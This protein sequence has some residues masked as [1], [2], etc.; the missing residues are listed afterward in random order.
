MRTTTQ[1][2]GFRLNV[3]LPPIFARI[4][5]LAIAVA[6]LL[7]S[8]SL[9]AGPVQNVVWENTVGVT[10]TG[11]SLT[12]GSST[13]A[14]NAG[15]ISTVDFASGNGYVQFTATETNTD[16]M[17]GMS[18][19][20]SSQ[21]YTDID[22]AVDLASNGQF[23]VFEDGVNRGSFGSYSTGDVFLV[24]VSGGVVSYS[25][26]GTLFYTSSATPSF[27]VFADASLETP[28]ATISTVKIS[29][30]LQSLPVLAPVFSVAAGTYPTAQT[31]TI[32][33]GTPGAQI[34]YTTDGSTPTQSSQSIASGGTV[35][36]AST[37]TLQLQAFETGL[38][39]STIATANYV[40]NNG[41]SVAWTNGVGVI[42]SGS[43]LTRGSGSAGWTAGAI[44]NT[45]IASG[46]GY[47]Q[48][49]A[50]E[51]NTY[52]MCGL[53]HDNSSEDYTD[54]DFA[55]YLAGNGQFYVYENGT[56]RGGFGSYSTGD[57]FTVAL[58]GG[59]IMYS[60][61]GT[62]FY[63]SSATPTL[64][65]FADVSLYS[66]G[67]TADNFV[68]SGTLQALLVDAPVFS[69]AAGTY[70]TTQSVTITDGT[71][72][73]QIYYTTN[74]STPT[75]SSQSIASGGTVLVASTL[76]LMAQAFE[77]GYTA[78][79]V[80]TAA[81][82]IGSA[83]NV[84]W[85]NGVDVTTSGNNLTR[86]SDTAGWTAGAIS[87]TEI[88]SGNGYVQ[89]TATETNTYRMCGLSHDNSS[90][91]YADI[92]FA[93]Y[94]ADNGQF[95]VYENGTYRGG[96]GSYSTGDV[97][98]VALTG[99][100]ITYSRNGTIFYT[101]SATPTLP[102]FADVSLYSP[103]ATVDNFVISGATASGPSAQ[104]VVWT[105]VVGATPSGNNLT[106]GSDTAG[107]TAGAI[108]NTEIASGNGYVQF[109]ATETNTY[110]MCGLSHDNSSENY[111]DIDF[112]VYLAG[113]GQFYVYE[114]GTYRGGFGSYS[115]GDVFTVAP[116]GGVITY[117]RNGTI[118]YTSSA[119]PTL[120]LFAD[121]SLYSP[122]AT[123]D[124]FV[125]SGAT[126]SG[127]SAQNVVWTNVVGATPSGNNLTRGSDTAGWTAGAISNTEIASG[128]GYVQFTA[129]ETNTY[130]MCGLSHDNSSENYA[131]IDFA[132]YLAGNGQFYVYEN[133]TY[134]GGFGSYSTGDVF[135]VAPT[136]G[137]I[138]YS[139]NGTI[140]YTSSATPTLPL[141]ADVSLYSPGATVGDVLF[142]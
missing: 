60:R 58:T 110:R 35:L 120:P 17:C 129:T 79:S 103:G 81:Y 80:T 67:A 128:N 50:T 101:S 75:Q 25:R 54:L 19:D 100:V 95:Y 26:N 112:A 65:L 56:Y 51:T 63:T 70:P 96:F 98:T 5:A 11:N 9:H 123:V 36:V 48:F 106:R 24:A 141:F 121:V 90:E 46:N 16:R 47:V 132:V 13:A 139:R 86:G 68:I 136:G 117:S 15:A 21:S 23:Y 4:I 41:Q 140:F 6:S 2:Q 27:P 22:F 10:A 40:I 57:V 99:G 33:D 71:S 137:V 127:P 138:T 94:L 76:T 52:R 12:R 115:T 84:V 104:N 93:V 34:Y 108:S 28:G 31:V 107:W 109:T 114:N 89:F 29:G 111:A 88:A 85:E 105:N 66:P 73:A 3:T 18:H 125:I 30:A 92:D 14:W 91:N 124:N 39:N 53:S 126:A 131:D 134:R 43:T 38:V 122:G 62:V 72:G 32:T 49:T 87:N 1:S 55:V 97:F 119:T 83:Q 64:P 45:E 42:A 113:N 74:G 130:R 82:V 133:G 61:N 116:T 77:T 135:T 59:V 37:L 78:S 44:S 118:F 20:N 69:I 8:T 7:F 142:Y 102:L